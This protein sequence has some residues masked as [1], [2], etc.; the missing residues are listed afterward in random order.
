MMPVR[1]RS[2]EQSAGIMGIIAEKKVVM[3]KR[4]GMQK[5]REKEF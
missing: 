5:W 3:R 1:V 2:T 4:T